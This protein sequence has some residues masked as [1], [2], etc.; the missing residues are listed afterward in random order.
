MHVR[1][2]NGTSLAIYDFRAACSDPKTHSFCESSCDLALITPPLGNFQRLR[3]CDFRALRHFLSSDADTGVVVSRDGTK[4]S[5]SS[6]D[7]WLGVRAAPGVIHGAYWVE[8]EIMGDCLLRVGWAAANS[9][10]TL[11]LHRARNQP[12]RVNREGYG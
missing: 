6:E 12:M 7:A 2:F 11:G 3:L 9:R 5:S 10:R 4:A 1:G 8:F